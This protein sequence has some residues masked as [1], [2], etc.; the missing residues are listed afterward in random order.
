MIQQTGQP[1]V[2]AGKAIAASLN[3]V[4]SLAQ[5]QPETMRRAVEELARNVD[6]DK[7]NL[8][9]LNRLSVLA[10]FWQNNPLMGKNMGQLPQYRGKLEA[11]TREEVPARSGNCQICGERGVFS[12]ANRSWFPLAAGADGDPCSLPNL[13]GKY[14]CADCFRAVLLL[15][16]GCRFCKAGPYLF[17]IADPDLQVE[18]IRDGVDAI[19][20]ARLARA[21]GNASIRTET[22]L[23][24]RLELLEIISGS[25]LWDRN[26]SEDGK[27]SHRASQGATIISFSNSGTS[28]A[29]NQLHLP[30]QALDFFA[31]LTES[32]RKGVFLQWAEKSKLEFYEAICDD[33]ESRRSLGPLL[34]ALVRARREPKLLREEADVLRIYEDVALGKAERFDTLERIA[35]RVNAMEVR[36]RNS[37]VKQLANT[38]TKEKFLQLLTQF[39]QSEKTDLRLSAAELRVLHDAPA[40]EAINLLYLLCVAEDNA[41]ATQS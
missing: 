25:G 3:G 15:P 9:A 8:G 37:F 34:G 16:M 24:G 26:Q 17:H 35:G 39:A 32:Q 1:L 11:L 41:S 2:D 12:D 31:A 19:R 33:I 28:A 40:S 7:A 21:S 22:R 18:A 29:W 30:A 5:V 14:L 23:S 38:R 4:Q 36:Y 27:L 6:P 13:R 20:T 10:A